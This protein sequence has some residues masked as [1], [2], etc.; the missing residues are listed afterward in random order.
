MTTGIRNIMQLLG[1]TSR[2]FP[3]FKKLLDGEPS[4][5]DRGNHRKG[6]VGKGKHVRTGHSVDSQRSRANRRKAKRK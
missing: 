2:T 3:N 6:R 1:M 4:N 5:F